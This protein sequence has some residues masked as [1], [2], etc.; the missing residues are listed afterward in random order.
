HRQLRA[1]YD[2]LASPLLTRGLEL[3][4]DGINGS[5]YTLL[6]ELKTNENAIIFGANTFWEGIDLPGLALTS[7]IIVRLPFAPPGQPLAEA[8]MEQMSQQGQDPFYHYSLPQAV[9]RFRQGYGR[10]IRTIDDWGVVVVLDN[11]IVNKRYGRVFLQSLPDPRC[12]TGRPQE[13]IRHIKDW[14]LRFLPAVKK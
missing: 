1:M 2:G 4:A 11:R 10:L 7:L 9:L 8:R 14:Q 3:F 13:L 6:E 5:R 12:V